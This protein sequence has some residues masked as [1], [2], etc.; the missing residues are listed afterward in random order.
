[1]KEIELFR[2][3]IAKGSRMVGS[4]VTLNDVM[5]TELIARHMD[6]VWIDME[7][8]AQGMD[9]VEGH[10]LVA[11][12]NGKSVVVRVPK[13]DMAWIKMA[14]DAGAH[15][16][17]IPQLYTPG[18]FRQ[19]VAFSRYAPVGKRGFGPRIPYEY[20]KM[21]S[22]KDYLEWANKNIYVAPQIETREAYENLDE[23]LEIEGFDAIC[24]GPADL[25]ISMGYWGDITCKEMLAIYEDIITKTKKAGKHAGFGMGVN[26]EYAK[27]I[28]QMGA[29]WLQ[30]GSD[31]D[32]INKLSE[33]I[34]IELKK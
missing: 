16:V 8:G 23:I 28:F 26:V 14:L 9:V 33:E 19:A 31:F 18:D 24:I 20:G 13:L 4:A 7:H 32:F 5:A 11:K 29:D 10:I 2:Q 12:K 27:I 22:A 15:G 1:M 30:I 25:S 21:G 34:Y 17:I 3:Q 6:F